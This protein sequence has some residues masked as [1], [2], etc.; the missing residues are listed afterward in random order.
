MTGPHIFARELAGLLAADCE[1]LFDALSLADVCIDGGELAGRLPNGDKVKMALRGGKRGKWLNCYNA[2]QKGDPLN[3][4]AWARFNGDTRQAFAWACN[5]LGVNG[6][7]PLRT[8]SGPAA[9]P[10][11]RR[12]ETGVSR[13][14]DPA[15]L[16]RDSVADSP[17]VAAYLQYRLGLPRAQVPP[18]RCLRFLPRL[19]HKE[20][21]TQP[22]VMLA[23]VIDLVSGRQIGTHI[24][25]LAEERGIVRKAPIKP[26]KK[27]RGR[28]LG[29]V[30]PLLEGAS[31]RPLH[32]MADDETLLVGE[33]IENSLAGAYLLRDEGPRVWSVVSVGNYPKVA[34]ALPPQ[35]AHVVIAADNNPGNE[36]VK[37]TLRKTVDLLIDQGRKVEFIRAP[38]Y[39]K[40][41]AEYLSHEGPIV[42]EEELG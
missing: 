14:S 41:L 6:D 30:I 20:T 34:A 7:R 22:P 31:G 24:T 39:H 26:D 33:G 9:T 19:W 21:D 36:G 32:A 38:A 3:L 40:D 13:Q 23:P 10:P 8:S 42:R 25:W 2:E 27:L 1:A 29:G 16:Y 4:V 15:G 17:M 28:F 35:I 37:G 12:V 11:V 18:V 5:W